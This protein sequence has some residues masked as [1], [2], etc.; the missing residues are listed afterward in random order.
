M[1]NINKLN[2]DEKK[3][4]EEK[5]YQFQATEVFF[6]KCDLYDDDSLFN[7]CNYLINCYYILFEVDDK[8]KDYENLKKIISCCL[9][10][11]IDK[12]INFIKGIRGLPSSIEFKIENKN[13][14]EFNPSTLTKDSFIKLSYKKISI[15]TKAED[16]NWNLPQDL[17]FDCLESDNFMFC[18]R[19]PKLNEI[20][21]INLNEDIKKYYKNL[22]KKI[23][24]SK[25]MEKCMNID[26]DASK[27]EYPFKDDN[28]IKEIEERTLFVPFPAKNFYGYSDRMSFTVYLNSSINTKNFKTLFIDYDN[29]IKSECHEYKHIYRLYM[30][31]NDPS[32]SLKTPKINRKTLSRNKLIKSNL[33]TFEKNAENLTKLYE[34]RIIPKNEN[35]SLDYGDILEFA[36]NGDKQ[37][38]FFIKNSLFCLSEK[39][40]DMEPKK[41]FES[42]FNSCNI[43][44]FKLKTSNEDNFI[45]SVIDFHKIPKNLEVIN[46]AYTSK[47]ATHQSI[48]TFFEGEIENSF[49]IIPRANHCG[50]KK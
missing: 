17:F 46:D 15:K 29:L 37:D 35:D 21:H 12:A 10:F 39:S 38:V 9:P 2:E 31:I 1:G 19:F 3:L 48:N 28:I 27:F 26:S 16:I 30:H 44:K 50:I 4:V 14:S 5:I 22:F 20:N 49:M 18:F 11:E 7:V 40:W 32:I 33:S 47:R 36:I 42:I 23:L 8:L 25:I 45:N 34:E 13:Y 6:Q 24:K 43:K 41:F